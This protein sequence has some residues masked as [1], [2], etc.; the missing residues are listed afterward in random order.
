[1]DASLTKRPGSLWER[2]VETTATALHSGALQPVETRLETLDEVGIRFQVRVL[3]GGRH[4]IEAG[5]AQAAA[6]TRQGRYV[7][8]FQPWEPDLYVTDVS[9][10]HVCLLNKYN[11]VDHHLLI[12]TRAFEHQM[13]PL[14]AGDFEAAWRCLAEFEGLVFY[15]AGRVAGASQEHRH[16][17]MVPLPLPDSGAGE[18]MPLERLISHAATGNGGSENRRL[19]FRHVIRAV[20]RQW[21]RDPI[22]GGRD[23]L[24]HYG[25]MLTRSGLQSGNEPGE[26]RLPPYNLLLTRK[27]IM[28]VPRS[29]APAVET[30]VNALGFAGA[31]LAGDETEFRA[32][33]TSGP[34]AVL[35]RAGLPPTA[36]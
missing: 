30:D 7:D 33:R 11:V 27:W 22:Q 25:E 36:R 9:D 17:Q 31:L 15:N 19:P 18:G 2:V 8:P 20:Q 1:M 6:S 5:R 16:L 12:V 10:T 21:L 26:A 35:G 32:I 13:A 23:T 29:E 24:S 28:F 3:T 4:K 34:F 14:T